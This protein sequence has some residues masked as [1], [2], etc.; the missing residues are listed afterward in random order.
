MKSNNAERQEMTNQKPPVD[1]EPITA[2]TCPHCGAPRNGSPNY[3]PHYMISWRCSTLAIRD[4]E[5]TPW[6]TIQSPECARYVRTRVSHLRRVMDCAESRACA[7]ENACPEDAEWAAK[8]RPKMVR[9]ANACRREL[10][11]LRGQQ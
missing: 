2:T 8:H 7:M 4:S 11:R 3:V 1:L 10:D 6:R 9:L 5:A